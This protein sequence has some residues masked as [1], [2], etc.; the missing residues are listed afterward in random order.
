[1]RKHIVF[2]IRFVFTPGNSNFG[3]CENRIVIKE[4]TCQPQFKIHMSQNSK[5][6]D[7]G[8]MKMQSIQ[9][10][11]VQNFKS[12]IGAFWGVHLT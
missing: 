8:Q 7:L 9:C 12:K 2:A 4:S 5:G 6:S 3:C 11:T 10:G 1:M